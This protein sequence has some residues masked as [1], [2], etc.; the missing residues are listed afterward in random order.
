MSRIA[1]FLFLI[2]SL[3]AAAI[4]AC[5]A[6]NFIE[7]GATLRGPGVLVSF[8]PKTKPEHVRTCSYARVSQAGLFEENLKRF[9]TEAPLTLT[10][11]FADNIIVK[12]SDLQ[13]LLRRNRE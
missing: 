6:L 8:R 2:L 4:D 11:G 12:G 9:Q 3:P 13:K 7:I 10:I 5:S 1:L